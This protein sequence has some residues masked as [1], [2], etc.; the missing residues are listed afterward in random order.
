MNTESI[1]ESLLFISGEPISFKK[2][3]GFTAINEGELE[4]SCGELSKKYND[5]NRGTMILIKYG[6]AQ[7]VTAGE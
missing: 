7:M 4:L 5:E 6:K 3:S 1:L 2:L